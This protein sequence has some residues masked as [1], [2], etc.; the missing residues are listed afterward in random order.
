MGAAVRRIA[1]EAFAGADLSGQHR[2]ALIDAVAGLLATWHAVGSAEIERQGTLRLQERA[3][4]RVV[5]AGI[6]FVARR[7]TGYE[8]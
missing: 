3:L 4:Q 7:G 1:A 5:A 8:Q 6:L 2:A